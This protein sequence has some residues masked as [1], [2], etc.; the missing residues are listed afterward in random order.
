MKLAFA[1]VLIASF[2]DTSSLH[3]YTNTLLYLM[4]HL[5]PTHQHHQETTYQPLHHFK[6]S[7]GSG[8]MQGSRVVIVI[9]K[10]QF[11]VLP[12]QYL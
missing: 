2:P 1:M 8:E 5:T 3:Q 7:V 12:F 4:F 9:G 6:V 10:Q 11:I